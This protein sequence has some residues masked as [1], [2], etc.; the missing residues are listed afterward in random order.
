MKATSATFF[1]FAAVLAASAP[2]AGVQNSSVNKAHRNFT[3]AH[4]FSALK[5]GRTVKRPV[6]ILASIFFNAPLAGKASVTSP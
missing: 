6:G 4:D 2:S 3:T 5:F 1:A